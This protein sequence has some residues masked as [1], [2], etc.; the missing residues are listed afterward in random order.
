[1]KEKNWFLRQDELVQAGIVLGG[2]VLFT[3]L[4]YFFLK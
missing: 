1:M 2:I 3:K 4:T